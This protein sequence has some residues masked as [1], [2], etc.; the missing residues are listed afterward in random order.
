MR[1]AR[2]FHPEWGYVAPAPSLI[3]R[4]RTVLVATAVG[5]A[6]G[7]SVVFSLV[8]RPATETSEIPV[9][10][11]TLAL[12]VRAASAPLSTPQATQVSARVAIQ[13]Q[14]TTPPVANGHEEPI[15][16]TES[17]TSSTAPP[18]T[19]IPALTEVPA[20]TN[21]VSA[22]AAHV[23]MP[24]AS[25]APATDLAPMQKKATKKHHFASRY[26]SR[27]GPLFLLGEYYGRP[28]GDR[29]GGFY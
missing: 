1:S 24:T 21:A 23:T 4:V 22:K 15:A 8:G 10:A 28:Y 20:P 11:R 27:S 16:A 9:A 19:G 26:A 7:A 12:P 18:P 13:N 17:S 5:A 2:N 29:R 14:S 25:A 3:R 6:A